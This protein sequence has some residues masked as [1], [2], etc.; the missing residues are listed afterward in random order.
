MNKRPAG[1]IILLI[2]LL[3]SFAS[4]AQKI[5]YV[6]ASA[7]GANN[8]TSWAN[9]FTSLRRAVDG[10][11]PYP[12]GYEIRVAAGTYK[13]VSTDPLDRL[14]SFQVFCGTRILGGYNAATGVRNIAANPTILSGELGSASTYD[15]SQNIMMIGGSPNGDSVI[16]DGLT[17]RAG[18]ANAESELETPHGGAI[19]I[20]SYDGS[21]KKIIRNCRF[22]NN[23]ALQNG[24]AI[25]TAD[26]LTRIEHCSFSGNS[27]SKGGAVAAS[28]GV[29]IYNSSFA[30]N[31]AIHSGG[32]AFLEGGSSAVINCSFTKNTSSANAG[33][34]G[35][36][37]LYFTAN[38]GGTVANCVLYN[39]ISLDNIPARQE[40]TKAGTATMLS[41]GTS[42]IQGYDNSAANNFTNAGGIITADPLFLNPND[43]DGADNLLGT[44]DDG[45]YMQPCS[46]AINAGLNA[47]LPS[48]YNTDLVGNPRVY[49]NAV[50]DLG[51]YELQ[52]P[53]GAGASGNVFVDAGIAT[54]GDGKTWATAFKTLKEA[55]LFAQSGACLQVDS[56]LVAKGTYFP[57]GAQS[58][59]DRNAAFTM[60]RGGIKIYGGYDAA[61]G[62][63]NLTTNQT[64]LSGAINAASDNDNSYNIM[65][66]AG[67]AAGG[68]SIV[69]DGFA[70]EKGNANEAVYYTTT[71]GQDIFS[72]FGAA[73]QL[74][75]ND[76]NQKILFRNCSFVQNMASVPAQGTGFGGAIYNASSPLLLYNC[77]FINNSSLAGGGAIY[78]LRSKA[79]L[80]NCSF[81]NN[82]AAQGGGIYLY[83]DAAGHLLD[84]VNSTF[85]ANTSTDA[86][87]GQSIHA[88]YA[89]ALPAAD[90]TIQIRNSII[91]QVAGFTGNNAIGE[92][93]AIYQVSNTI[94]Q[95]PG[96]GFDVQGTYLNI[97]PKFN[98][99]ADAAGADNIAG[100]V[101]DGLSL[102]PCSPAVNA[103]NN[104]VIPSG[105]AT[106]IAGN[107]RTFNSNV[108]LGAYEL[109]AAPQPVDNVNRATVY[110]NAA[111]PVGG[112]GRSWATALRYLGD[113]L[114]LINSY[115]D[116]KPVGNILVAGGTYYPVGDRP[117]TNQDAAFVITGGNIR[118][119]GGYDAATGLRDP[120]AHPSV[121][122]GAID[123]ATILNSSFHIMAIVGVNAADDSLVIDGF[124]FEK[125]RA[126][127][128]GN[129]MINGTA[130]ARNNGA[131]LITQNNNGH[132]RTMIRN[133]YFSNNL[134]TGTGGAVE[135]GSNSI[136]HFENCRFISNSASLLGGAVRNSSSTGPVFINCH[137]ISN[138]AGNRGGAMQNIDAAS[139]IINCSFAGNEN[140]GNGEGGAID[141][142]NSTITLLN[143][144]FVRNNV[145][146]GN[147]G[148]AIYV[149]GTGT[150]ISNCIF[151]GNTVGGSNST[152]NSSQVWFGTSFSMDHSIVQNG[153]YSGTG[154]RSVDPLFADLNDFDGADNVL[155]TADD[156]LRLQAC[157]PAINTGNNAALPA[158][159]VTD[160]S[161]QN[162]IQFALVDMGA[163][164]SSVNSLPAIAAANASITIFQGNTIRYFSGCSDLVATV[165]STGANAISGLTTARVWIEPVQPAEFVKRHYEITPSGGTATATGRITLYFTQAEFD[166]FN[167]V[168]SV[169]LPSGPADNSGKMNLRIEKRPGVSNNGT[170]LPDTY[171]GTPVTI[172]PAETDIVWNNT[173]SRWEVSFDVS[174]FSGFFVKTSGYPLPLKLIRFGGT[175]REGVSRLSWE[176]ASEVNV[177]HFEVERSKNGQ[178][179][180]MIGK[181]AA[182]NGNSQS[183]FF[184]DTLSFAGTMQY[185]LRM[186]DVDGKF[187]YSQVIL[188]SERTASVRTI[189]P[190]PA[191][192][193]ITIQMDTPDFAGKELQI[194][195]ARGNTIQRVMITNR[196][197]KLYVGRLAAGLYFV[198]FSDGSVERFI[199]Q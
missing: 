97:D 140:T 182:G 85:A 187:S 10:Y 153:G 145:Q 190:N 184:N 117:G 18:S 143:S 149:N 135:N 58:S 39:N 87:A 150:V 126:A 3:C 109:Q 74:V 30:G 14:A 160:L 159:I 100:T 189:S 128:T 151:W 103:G 161:G 16:V 8:G 78:N 44:A 24:G 191:T 158:G 176:T 9:A 84:I 104:A 120:E 165:H 13:P 180:A 33:F 66:I 185:R 94:L 25:F 1:V 124:R 102:Q 34:T 169:K 11:S 193:F 35:G 133:C 32:G 197:L 131:A 73:V 90:R 155:G 53:S 129:Y 98:N 75:N 99:Y 88:Q 168:N 127:G 6:N 67:V 40:I 27:A 50:I 61:T 80:Y 47:L 166:A 21:Y 46:P 137:F 26:D 174:G 81:Y 56:I 93:D 83:S 28:F 68:D 51:A 172:D 171:T 91:W 175:R 86:T 157:S 92:V 76:I 139:T 19:A 52:A 199:K 31:S 36:G 147:G 130:V 55:L 146:T 70:F 156:G 136:P 15:N 177:S 65:V 125:G 115:I 105:I 62:I 42:V 23:Y 41:V 173:E 132:T 170:G 71:N 111:A 101:D 38:A 196:Q 4:S 37:A 95:Y 79:G 148:A 43:P 49:N 121:L 63:R 82:R 141:N 179:F 118:I 198:R 192:A 178:A 181:L 22:I 96:T 20:F 123:P 162:R 29:K 106:D 2:Y 134:A 5:V 142:F 108:D 194:L 12:G 112:D 186:V 57:T 164:E 72:C 152:Q 60:L 17:F 122:S 89:A 195:D 114:G 116:C 64:T 154:N 183:Y 7:T 54:S 45:L 48:F 138:R 144:S 188:L 107:A 119:M 59:S 69:V 163:Y 167:A 77:S 113:A 110:V